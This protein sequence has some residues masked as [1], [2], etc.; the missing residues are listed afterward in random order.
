M[1]PETSSVYR[2]SLFPVTTSVRCPGKHDGTIHFSDGLVCGYSTRP[3]GC[4]NPCCQS[5]PH[6]IVLSLINRFHLGYLNAFP[7]CSSWDVT[8][9]HISRSFKT[10]STNA[11]SPLICLVAVEAFNNLEVVFEQIESNIFGTYA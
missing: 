6:T 10:R 2:K 1:R 9:E 8:S 7:F 3:T 5:M 11:Q 4:G